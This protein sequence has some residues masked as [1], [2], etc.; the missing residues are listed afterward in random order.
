MP[1][2]V[3][4][5]EAI[6]GGSLFGGKSCFLRLGFFAFGARA[7]T[8]QF[9]GFR[10]AVWHVLFLGLLFAVAWT[11]CLTESLPFS[12]VLEAFRALTHFSIW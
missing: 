8:L 1:G 11:T 12:S 2:W 7:A 10:P 5:C 4:F 3:M 6:M 9:T